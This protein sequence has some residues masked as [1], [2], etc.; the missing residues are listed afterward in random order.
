VQ[1]GSRTIYFLLESRSGDEKEFTLW[2]RS[3]SAREELPYATSLEYELESS[4]SAQAVVEEILE[5]NSLDWG[6]QDWNLPASFEFAGVPMEGV[7]QIASAIGAVVRCKD[8][9]T[10]YIRQRFPVRPINMNDGTVAVNYNRKNLTALGYEEGKGTGYNKIEVTGATSNVDL[11]TLELEESS[12]LQSTDVH[13]RAYWAGKKPTEDPILYVTDGNADFLKD[14]TSE[15]TEVVVFQNGVGSVAYPISSVKSTTWIGDSGVNITYEKHSS[16]LEIDDEAYRVATLVYNTEYS[17]YKLS[18]H[19]VDLLI[20]LLTFGGES[21][22]SVSVKFGDGDV[23]APDLAQA[24][25]TSQSIAV[26]AGTAWLDSNK[27]SWKRIT[28]ETPYSDDA[29][30]GVLAYINDAE[31]DCLGKFHIRS[32]KIIFDGIRILNEIKVLQCQTS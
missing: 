20:F 17:K 31:V 16:D 4:K 26:V 10:V 19:D 22:V 28:I 29:I 3:L 11:P 18:N 21:D 23:Q 7:Q 1:V 27:Y 5:V 24:F 12:P 6:V 30:D 13:I 2:G 9:G 8:D 32:C 15:E 25:L 14:D